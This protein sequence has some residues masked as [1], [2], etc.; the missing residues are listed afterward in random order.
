M[1][2]QQNDSDIRIQ[3]LNNLHSYIDKYRVVKTD[4]I[5][6]TKMTHTS[7]G[8]FLGSFNIPDDKLKEFFKL[9]QRVIKNGNIPGILETHLE[10]GPLIID[11]DFKYTL[12]ADTLNTRIYT[13]QD[14]ENIIRIF[15]QIIFTY[16]S[17]N[18]DDI[19]IYILEKPKA[20]IINKEHPTKNKISYKDGIHVMN[21][22]VCANNK[23]QL[24][25]REL[26][27]NKICYIHLITY[28]I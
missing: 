23:V 27:V 16:L 10:Q 20:K 14:I 26:L 22:Y 1:A 24:Y 3:Q 12:N 21:P 4:N 6:N 18:P 2:L 13:N 17:V 15:N 8:S 5:K 28:N 25:F 9:Y 11:L 19:E 7:M